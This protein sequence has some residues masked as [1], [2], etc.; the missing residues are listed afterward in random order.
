MAIFSCPEAPCSLSFLKQK[1]LVA[2]LLAIHNVVL[3]FPC[4]IISCSEVF[5]TTTLRSTHLYD[6]H[7]PVWYRAGPDDERPVRRMK[8]SGKIP[9][10]ILGCTSKGF[11][12]Q[13]SF[14]THMEKYHHLSQGDESEFSDSDEEDDP[15]APACG[16]SSRGEEE[17]KLTLLLMLTL[18]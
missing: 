1:L 17:G 15:P 16:Q 13:R 6:T 4:T 18:N 9:C 3:R 14:H 5:D 8:G 7:H 12:L 2:H 11:A 10:P